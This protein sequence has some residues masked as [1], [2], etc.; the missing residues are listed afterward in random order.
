MYY[1]EDRLTTSALIECYYDVRLICTRCTM[2]NKSVR[3]STITFSL[4][5]NHMPVNSHFNQSELRRRANMKNCVLWQ[6]VLVILWV[7]YVDGC[8]NKRIH[9]TVTFVL[10]RFASPNLTA[11][12]TIAHRRTTG[13]ISTWDNLW[14]I[15]IAMRLRLWLWLRQR[16]WAVP[17]KLLW[18]KNAGICAKRQSTTPATG[19][20]QPSR[21]K[22]STKNNSDSNNNGPFTKKMK[23]YC[24]KMK[25]SAWKL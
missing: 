6:H 17:A 4:C 1:H 24:Q 8:G 12:T 25:K 20:T 18:C 15:A 19:A 22:C 21:S 16:Q 11:T 13:K 5:I 3:I 10:L 23:I 9:L 2:L 14:A 7:G